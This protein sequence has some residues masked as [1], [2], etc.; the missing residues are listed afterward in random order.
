MPI[1]SSR[2]KN[3]NQPVRTGLRFFISHENSNL[4]SAP[5]EYFSEVVRGRA[6]ILDSIDLLGT[7]PTA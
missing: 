7:Q 1:H 6:S 4:L 2:R 5:S 3:A